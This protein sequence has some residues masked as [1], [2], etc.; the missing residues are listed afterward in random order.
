VKKLFGLISVSATLTYLICN[1]VTCGTPVTWGVFGAEVKDTY[2]P[3][4]EDT[5]APPTVEFDSRTQQLI[6]ELGFSGLSLTDLYFQCGKALGHTAACEHI[7][8]S[9]G[10]TVPDSVAV[11]LIKLKSLTHRM[12]NTEFG[13]NPEAPLTD[14]LA[15]IAGLQAKKIKIVN[16]SVGE[17]LV[18]AEK[19]LEELYYFEAVVKYLQGLNNTLLID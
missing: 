18:R 2:V 8:D 7:C 16:E 1:C 14:I 6:K 3:P 4:E 9:L 12:L 5:Y 10:I 15:M 19:E 17:E 11:K 13:L